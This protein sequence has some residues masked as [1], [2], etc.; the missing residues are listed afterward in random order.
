MR[1]AIV[2][3][4]ADADPRVVAFTTEA[5]ATAWRIEYERMTENIWESDPLW[6]NYPRGAER[7]LQP[8][9]AIELLR[10]EVEEIKQ[11]A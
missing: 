11:T 5:D 10:L 7:I 1:Y 9:E 4:Q 3:E 8:Y 6:H 2:I